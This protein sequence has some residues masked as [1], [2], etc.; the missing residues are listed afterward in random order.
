ME[1]IIYSPKLVASLNHKHILL[2]TNIFRDYAAKP[3]VFTR[4]FNFLKESDVTITTLNVVKY[5]FLKGSSN[6]EKYSEKLKL[7]ESIID[8]T[9][10]VSPDTDALVH[11]LILK[12]GIDGS[13]L[14]LADL[15]LG[16]TLMKYGKNI[17][18][19]TR[20]TNDFVQNIFRLSEVV[21]VPINKGIFTYGIYQFIE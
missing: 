2:D 16:A 7:V 13:S 14:S 18:L 4:F 17:F 6:K 19:L 1:G 9:I 20:D 15:F 3:T 8:T 12:Y 5:E 21:N 10:T 11:K